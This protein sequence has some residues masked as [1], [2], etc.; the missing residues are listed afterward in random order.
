MLPLEYPIETPEGSIASIPIKK[1]TKIIMSVIM[2]NRYEKTW[3]ERPHEFWPERWIDHKLDEVT[4]P[5]AHLPGV[6]SSMYVFLFT[7][8][9]H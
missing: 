8:D 4:E 7:F 2:A 6:Y 9:I 5:G 3:G 1:G